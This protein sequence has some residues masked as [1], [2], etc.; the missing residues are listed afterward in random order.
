MPSRRLAALLFFVFV[1]DAQ[2][3]QPIALFDGKTLN[4]WTTA[5]GKPV[6]RGWT[7]DD[8]AIFLKSR[9]G[10]IFSEREFGDFELSFEWKISEGGNSGIK[11]RVRRFPKKGFLGCEYQILDDRKHRDEVVQ[12]KYRLAL[13]CVCTD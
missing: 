1:T 8:G 3:G 13:R 6:T 2:A 10:N 9:G 12:K 4:G 7:V 11:Y 5:N